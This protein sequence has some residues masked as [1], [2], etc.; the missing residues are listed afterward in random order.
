MRILLMI[1]RIFNAGEASI[2]RISDA[3]NID[4]N[5]MIV[6]LSDTML[7]VHVADNGVYRFDVTSS[8]LV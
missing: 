7:L 8:S 5:N 6:A 2:T 4:C 1:A 3:P